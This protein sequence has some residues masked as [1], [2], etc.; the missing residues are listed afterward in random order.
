MSWPIRDAQTL[1]WIV[2]D[3]RLELGLS[4]DQLATRAEV[5]RQW[6]TGLESGNHQNPSL[7]R[8]L[9]VLRVLNVNMRAHDGASAESAVPVALDEGDA[10][11]LDGVINAHTDFPTV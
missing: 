2:R 10:S 6:L 8:V 4:Q 7:T 9:R 1:G 11:V 5:G 3:H